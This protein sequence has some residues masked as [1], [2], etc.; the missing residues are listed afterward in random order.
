MIR[1]AVLGQDVSR[2][3]SPAIHGAAYAALKLEGRYEAVSVDAAHFRRRVKDLAGEGYRYVNVT[4]PYKRRAAQLATKRSPAVEMTGAANTLVFR[5]S[6]AG[7]LEI[8][9]DNTDGEGLIAALADMGVRLTSRTR[10]VMIGAGGAAA[11]ALLAMAKRGAHVSVLA[12]RPAPARA[13]RARLP[14]R[15]RPRVT[16]ATLTAR[17]LTGALQEADV[18]VSAVPA[19][20]WDDPALCQAIEKLPKT[21][22]VLEMAYGASSGLA[23]AAS[24]RTPRYQNGLPMLVHQAAHAIGVALRKKP[25]VAPLFRAV[26]HPPPKARRRS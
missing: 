23:K 17:A 2:S 3:Q 25:P 24:T 18:V 7:G 19:A 15:W 12:R 13:L 1:A 4:I 6:R 5:R 26:G 16:T 9:A 20:A 14:E 8:F 10:V 21:A 22:A 11:G